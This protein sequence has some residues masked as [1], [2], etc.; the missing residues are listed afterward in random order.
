ML[1]GAA[2]A[3]VVKLVL[4]NDRAIVAS[5]AYPVLSIVVRNMI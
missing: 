3:V 4:L 1:I 5:T 2:C